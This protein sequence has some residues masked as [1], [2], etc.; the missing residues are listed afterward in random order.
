MTPA[1]EELYEKLKRLVIPALRDGVITMDR[2]SKILSM[3]YDD[4]QH[5]LV[6]LDFEEKMESCPACK[7]KGYINDAN[8]WAVCPLNCRASELWMEKR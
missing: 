2:A 4:L 7:G 5:L 8:L 3:S 1:Q 6:N